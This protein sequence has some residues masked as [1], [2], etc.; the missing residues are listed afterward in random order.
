M[1]FS[2]L[3]TLSS[4][5]MMGT[6][7]GSVHTLPLGIMPLISRLQFIPLNTY[8]LAQS[9]AFSPKILSIKGFKE[10]PGL[11]IYFWGLQKTHSHVCCLH[12]DKYRV[13]NT[14]SSVFQLFFHFPSNFRGLRSRRRICPSRHVSVVQWKGV[15]HW[16]GMIMES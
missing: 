1:K 2:S 3:R 12:D 7:E 5:R 15:V 14:L 11:M 10:S 13:Y 16:N 6:H 8:I 4:R 9:L